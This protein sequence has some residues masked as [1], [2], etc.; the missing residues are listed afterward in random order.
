MGFVKAK[1]AVLTAFLAVLAGRN[2]CLDGLRPQP[3]YGRIDRP[4]AGADA[5]FLKGI[6]VNHLL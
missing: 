4:A 5:T 3:C 6:V 2:A 1:M